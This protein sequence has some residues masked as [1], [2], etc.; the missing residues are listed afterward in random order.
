[1]DGTS[2]TTGEIRPAT[3]SDLTA[4]QALL[5]SAL[6]RLAGARTQSE[7]PWFSK[8]DSADDFCEENLGNF[9]VITHLGR[10]EG[11]ALCYGGRIELL[12][13]EPRLH[14]KGLG[15]QLL[16]YCEQMMAEQVRVMR[17]EVIE[18]DPQTL[19][20][21]RHQGWQVDATRPDANYDFN[22]IML[23]KNAPQA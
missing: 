3:A 13:I 18:S 1:M 21:Y 15:G 11:F 19:A 10:V 12:V 14:A 22:R 5:R 20:F 16:N 2:L 8:A 17:A 7:T 4:I 6:H 23:I 9:S